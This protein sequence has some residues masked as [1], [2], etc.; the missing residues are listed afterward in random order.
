MKFSFVPIIK[1]FF[2]T[3]TC[4][5]YLNCFCQ[6]N[7]AS[8]DQFEIKTKTNYW[9]YSVEF[10]KGDKI[11]SMRIVNLKNIDAKAYSNKIPI[12][13]KD[14]K[15]E[16]VKKQ[17]SAEI[18]V[19]D[20]TLPHLNDSIVWSLTNSNKLYDALRM[21][22]E[23]KI[24]TIK[25]IPPKGNPDTLKLNPNRPKDK[26]EDSL[27]DLSSKK[28]DTSQ[29]NP[30]KYEK[31]DT[32]SI[33]P[34]SE[35]SKN[36]SRLVVKFTSE[37][38]IVKGVEFGNKNECTITE[39]I[40]VP[41]QK[42]DQKYH[43]AIKNDYEKSKIADSN[44]FISKN[45]FEISQDSLKTDSFSTNILI[46]RDS[47]HEHYVYLK[48]VVYDSLGNRT[49]L[50]D[51]CHEK[52][53]LV[54]T[55]KPYDSTNIDHEFWLFIGTNLDLVDG[56]QA[57]D[58][59]FRADYLSKIKKDQWFF[60]SL[61]K[62]RYFDFSDTVYKVSYNSV[63][64]PPI[65][66]SLKYVS[67][68]FN[69]LRVSKTENLFLNLKYLYQF[70]HANL[71]S[72]LFLETGVDLQYLTVTRSWSGITKTDSSFKN[73]PAPPVNMPGY[74]PYPLTTF[75]S[76][77]TKSW[78]YNFSAG[79][80][81][82]F[83]QDELNFKTQLIFGLNYTQYPKTT[84]FTSSNLELDQYTHNVAFF[85]RFRIDATVLNPGVSLGF[86]IYTTVQK[87]TDPYLEYINGDKKIAKPLFN[88]SL[89]KVLDVK[90]IKNLLGGVTPITA[91]N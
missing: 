40:I 30:K 67:G 59:Y 3:I 57:Q 61:G 9:L 25:A 47:I 66:D 85:T 49:G 11:D 81:H 37:K 63:T 1:P 48:L 83:N 80:M 10:Y 24:D 50:C 90:H 7:L 26:N 77:I 4:L 62:N 69:G 43:I 31:T 84:S 17:L 12:S 54:E 65:N 64:Y 58:L 14:K 34:D 88:I 46:R 51:T 8:W 60:I 6:S 32:N 45:E 22:S 15:L 27:K 89:T 19:F 23:M 39:T 28:I 73:V 53:I 21:L 29:V 78:N 13:S 56:I 91:T 79:L 16:E 38:D 75:N 42:K 74:F 36:N 68:H 41:K 5:L 72:R 44:V 20:K 82:I 70:S 87:S 33:K 71:N 55:Y 52:E 18:K 76:I 86:E 2:S 35:K